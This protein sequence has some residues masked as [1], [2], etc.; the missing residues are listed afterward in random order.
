M[1]EP[2][3]KAYFYIFVDFFSLLADPRTGTKHHLYPR[4][5]LQRTVGDTHSLLDFFLACRP[6]C[7]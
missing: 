6:F 3:R 1:I 5:A 2:H 4:F 7:F